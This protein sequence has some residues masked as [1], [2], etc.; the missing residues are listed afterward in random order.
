MGKSGCVSEGGWQVRS[1]GSVVA[2]E[3]G[4]STDNPMALP[5]SVGK[6]LESSLGSWSLQCLIDFIVET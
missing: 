4:L 5:A 1:P 3:N 2:K 6:S